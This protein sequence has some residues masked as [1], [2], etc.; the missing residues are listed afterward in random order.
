MLQCVGIIREREDRY[1]LKSPTLFIFGEKDDVIPLE[2]V[3][4]QEVCSFYKW[5]FA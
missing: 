2:Q 5:I 3:S 4:T 1:E